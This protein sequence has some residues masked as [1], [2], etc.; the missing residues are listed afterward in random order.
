MVP[1]KCA[2]GEEFGKTPCHAHQYAFEMCDILSKVHRYQFDLDWVQEMESQAFAAT[3]GDF[4]YWDFL[5]IKLQ[6]VT[7]VV[8][9]EE[10][11]YKIPK[12]K[13]KEDRRAP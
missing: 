9:G 10:V 7:F 11:T 12:H 4:T 5:M 6:E 2:C 3:Q 8:T 13:S 1:K